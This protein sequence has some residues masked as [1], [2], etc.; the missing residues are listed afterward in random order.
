MTK[1]FKTVMENKESY[2]K[3]WKWPEAVDVPVLCVV[4]TKQEDGIET[5]VNFRVDSSTKAAT[6]PD[7]EGLNGE[8]ITIYFE[9]ISKTIKVH[10]CYSGCSLL[11]LCLLTLCYVILADA[12]L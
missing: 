3:S 10:T 2:T 12:S 11:H 7:G 9:G 6:L 4:R 1:H 8:I 5:G